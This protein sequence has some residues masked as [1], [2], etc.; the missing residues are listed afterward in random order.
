MQFTL[1]LCLSWIPEGDTFLLTATLMGHLY[2]CLFSG[3][4]G[5]RWSARSSR[6]CGCKGMIIKMWSQLAAD[7]ADSC[8]R[9]SDTVSACVW[10][11]YRKMMHSTNQLVAF[12]THWFWYSWLIGF[13]W[14]LSAALAP[15]NRCC[16]FSRVIKVHLGHLDQRSW[17]TQHKSRISSWICVNSESGA[18]R[19][20][21]LQGECGSVGIQGPPG[22]GGPQGRRGPP[23]PPGSPGPPGPPAANFFV[24]VSIARYTCM[25]P[26]DECVILFVWSRGRVRNTVTSTLCATF[27]CRIWRVLGRGMCFLELESKAHRSEHN[28]WLSLDCCIKSKCSWFGSFQGPPGLPGVQGSKVGFAKYDQQICWG[29]TEVILELLNWRLKM[30]SD[31]F[32]RV[33]MELQG[34]L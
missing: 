29:V 31:V 33:R 10:T 18:I 17:V 6:K 16:C 9:E 8:R 20:I 21:V 15:N 34:F 27:S 25:V 32:C 28:C 26:L 5:K 19:C 14:V 24:E 12:Y 7:D 11:N 1:F 4:S 22:P 30:F 3:T 13:P 2:T 23:G